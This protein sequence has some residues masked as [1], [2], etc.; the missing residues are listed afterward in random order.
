MQYSKEQKIKIQIENNNCI[1]SG[2][3]TYKTNSNIST[4]NN[5]KTS[6]IKKFQKNLQNNLENDISLS[7]SKSQDNENYNNN[8]LSMIEITEKSLF[9]S[10]FN[11]GSFNNK[12]P[13]TKKKNKEKKIK[14]MKEAVIRKLNFDLP[15]KNYINS[16]KTKK[17]QENKYP[18]LNKII[19]NSHKKPAEKKTINNIITK[20]ITKKIKMNLNF[21]E[22]NLHNSFKRNNNS[23]EHCNTINDINNK[24]K[25]ISFNMNINLNSKE[26]IKK[27]S[28]KNSLKK[29]KKL[30]KQISLTLNTKEKLIKDNNH[31]SINLNKKNKNIMFNYIHRNSIN[32]FFQISTQKYNAY[33][34]TINNSFTIKDQKENNNSNNIQKQNKLLYINDKIKKS[35]LKSSNNSVSHSRRNTLSDYESDMKKNN[36]L[37]NYSIF[38]NSL[39]AS[40][41]RGRVKN[42]NSKIKI[43]KKMLK[44]FGKELYNPIESRP[45]EK[46][47]KKINNLNNISSNKARLSKSLFKKIN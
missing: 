22:I 9:N 27:N 43:L 15:N 1:I 40:T 36:K 5:T 2:F 19:F 17:I 13:E 16:S 28:T 3:N 45:N 24:N 29:Q 25:N 8:D 21:K 11:N 44:I 32:K 23:K 34:T 4:N 39:K 20:K 47:N 41:T 10:E 33:L 37:Y 14:K 12:T 38:G 26:N 46:I 18:L 31:N 30:K 7:I 35:N 6:S 42:K